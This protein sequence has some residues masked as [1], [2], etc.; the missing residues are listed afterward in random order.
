MPISRAAAEIEPESRMLSRSLALPGPI[1]APD[2]KTTLTLSLAMPALCHARGCE[3]AT[4]FRLCRKHPDPNW[5]Y[6]DCSP[7]ILA[8]HSPGSSLR[9]ELKGSRH[10]PTDEVGRR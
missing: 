8:A 1:R 6:M 10:K 7:L 4:F 9:D 5:R 3:I 2:S